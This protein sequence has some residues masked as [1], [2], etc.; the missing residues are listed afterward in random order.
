MVMCSLRQGFRIQTKVRPLH[1][2]VRGT[3]HVSR[4]TSFGMESASQ[5]QQ[6]PTKTIMRVL[7]KLMCDLTWK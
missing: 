1:I 4:V 3:N 5:T 6:Y 2:G 7:C